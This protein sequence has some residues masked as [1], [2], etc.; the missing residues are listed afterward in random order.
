MAMPAVDRRWTAREVRALIDQAPLAVE[1]ERSDGSTNVTY[2]N[3][4]SSISTRN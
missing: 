2:L 4:G 3:I 1:G